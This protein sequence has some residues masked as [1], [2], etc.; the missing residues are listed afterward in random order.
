VGGQSLTVDNVQLNLVPSTG[1]LP[2]W[3]NASA[4][5]VCNWNQSTE[6]LVISSGVVTI[7]DD[8]AE[9]RFNSGHG[10]DPMITVIGPGSGVVFDTQSSYAGGDASL[11]V[12]IGGLSLAG[13][14][15]ANVPSL[16]TARSAS[17]HM[18]L[19]VGKAGASSPPSFG[20]DAISQLDLNDNDLLIHDGN[21]SSVAAAVQSGYNRGASLWE[22]GGVVSSNAALGTLGA[23]GI[24]QTAAAGTF[25]GESVSSGDVELRYTYYGDATL[26]GHVDSAD[27]ARIDSG[28]LNHMTGWTN[29]DFNY[30]GVIN[31]SDYS[32]IDNA[33]N[34]EGASFDSQIATPT[35]IAKA[36]KRA[37]FANSSYADQ[38]APASL[39]ESQKKDKHQ[40]ISELLL[41]SGEDA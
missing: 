18:V 21:L 27:Y 4:G 19:V 38:Y 26:D 7:L 12:H 10:D 14:A 40:T 23:L 15:A 17:N 11:T 2:A 20:I 32:L 28:F 33:F 3:A 37:P 29:G 9:T 35:G 22:G 25:D 36:A 13:G 1:V 24:G 5:A 8:P 6:S 30:D 31:G 34:T 39:G 41:S 16:G